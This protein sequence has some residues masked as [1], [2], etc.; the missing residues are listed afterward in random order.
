MEIDM[1]Q[2]RFRAGFCFGHQNMLK[3][4]GKLAENPLLKD[5]QY[6]SVSGNMAFIYT[7]YPL[8]TTDK[9]EP[10]NEISFKTKPY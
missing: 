10:D 4:R 3:V 1:K 5:A 6:F 8:I 9:Q 7:A 2:S